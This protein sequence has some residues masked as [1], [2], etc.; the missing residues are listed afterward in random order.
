M[1]LMRCVFEGCDRTGAPLDGYT[2]FACERCLDQLEEHLSAEY[3]RRL[4]AL[5]TL[6]VL[7]RP[8]IVASIR[9]AVKL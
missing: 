7:A 2:Y 9:M 5:A 8:K 6:P 4:A 1:E 3:E